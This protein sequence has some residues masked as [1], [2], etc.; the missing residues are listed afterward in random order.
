MSE[1]SYYVTEMLLDGDTARYFSMIEPADKEW[2]MELIEKRRLKHE[3]D[4]AD[5]ELPR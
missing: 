4:W 2:L 3:K 1:N 5:D